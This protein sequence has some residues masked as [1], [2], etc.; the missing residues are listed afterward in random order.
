MFNFGSVSK[1]KLLINIENPN[2]DNLQ[3]RNVNYR[4]LK[5]TKQEE[6]TL[7]LNE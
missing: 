2:I 6:H 1:H 4:K 3:Q 7:E 5:H